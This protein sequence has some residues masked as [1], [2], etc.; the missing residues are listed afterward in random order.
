MEPQRPAPVY[1]AESAHSFTTPQDFYRLRDFG[2]KFE[3]T[4]AFLGKHGPNLYK[5]LLVPLAVALVPLA[6]LILLAASNQELFERN[7]MVGLTMLPAFIGL[8]L[9][10]LAALMAQYAMIYGFVKCRMHQPDP[11]QPL[12]VGEVWA[13]ARQHILPL[14]GY[15]LVA[16]VL[17][18]IGMLFL[19]LPGIY[20]YVV[21]LLLPC[22]V[23]FE[24]SELGTS[25]SRCF[26]LIKGK[27]WSTFGLFLV[28]SIA[29]GMISGGLGTI[30]AGALIATDADVPTDGV[31]GA[32][33][34]LTQAIQMAVNFILY[35]VLYILLMFQYFNLVERR[36]HVSLQWRL[37]ELGLTPTIPAGPASDDAPFRPS[38]GDQ[39]L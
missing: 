38:Y 21:L 14:L 8:G 2:Q 39:T 16:A 30:M 9:L 5:V 20:L 26:S 18:G 12:T 1:Q 37:E 32:G 24:G 15:F 36:D 4:L 10:I 17:I 23:V 22:V 25:F 3:A 7:S 6:L 13:E 33:F 11:A 34:V 28:A 31:M 19:I 29:I 27:W 35:P